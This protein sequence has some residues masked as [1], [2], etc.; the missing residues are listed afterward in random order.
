MRSSLLCPSLWLLQKRFVLVA[1]V[2][3]HEYGDWSMQVN[4]ISLVL[5]WSI[6][7]VLYGAI[8]ATGL[9]VYVYKCWQSMCNLGAMDM[10]YLTFLML[11][12]VTV[13]LATYAINGRIFYI[14]HQHHAKQITM[15]QQFQEGLGD[16]LRFVAKVRV[17]RSVFTSYL[18]SLTERRRRRRRER[19]K[20]K[21]KKR[22]EKNGCHDAAVKGQFCE[23]KWH[24]IH[25]LEADP[26]EQ[27]LLTACDIP[28]FLWFWFG[29][30]DSFIYESVSLEGIIS[31]NF[32]SYFTPHVIMQLMFLS[33]LT[34]FACPIIH[35][36]QTSSLIGHLHD[37]QQSDYSS[38]VGHWHDLQL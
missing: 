36:C 5:I 17:A 1:V 23:F 11:F 31:T 7:T 13:F 35:H 20:K 33:C 29:H 32:L 16:K 6:P 12:S 34:W 27:W 21:K 22:R 30:K 3:Y 14:A 19:E 4:V 10:R 26:T 38:L 24:Y 28:T 8:P 25:I 18:T 15:D 37:S 9:G 2:Q